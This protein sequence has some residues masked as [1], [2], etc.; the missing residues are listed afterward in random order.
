MSISFFPTA[1]HFGV[2]SQFEEVNMT[3][4]RSVNTSSS[5]SRHHLVVRTDIAS[6]AEGGEDNLFSSHQM[7]GLFLFISLLFPGRLQNHPGESWGQAGGGGLH[8][9][10][11]RPL[12]TDWPEV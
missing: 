5:D 1:F 4:S 2:Y 9:H 12:Q 11:V 6:Q 8:R 10:V 7:T 3:C